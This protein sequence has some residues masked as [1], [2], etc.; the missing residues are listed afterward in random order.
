MIGQMRIKSIT[1]LTLLFCLLLNEFESTYAWSPPNVQKIETEFRWNRMP[2]RHLRRTTTVVNAISNDHDTHNNK[3]YQNGIFLKSISKQIVASGV[4]LIASAF[5]C[6]DNALAASDMPVGKRYW[7]IMESSS[8]EERIHANEALLD[9]AVGTI[10]TQYYDNTGGNNFA[11]S[12]FY[13]QW[14][15][16]RRMAVSG[17]AGA[18]TPSRR[19]ALPVDIPKGVSLDTRDGAVQGLRWLVGSLNDPFSKYLTREELQQE[20][21]LIGQDGFLGTGAIVEAP[22][23]R[24]RPKMSSDKA[25]SP[26]SVQDFHGLKKVLSIARAANLPVVTAVEPDS[27]AERAGF[28]VG[29]RI[30]AVGS[31]SFLGWS[32]QEV[33]KTLATKYNAQSYFGQAELTIAKPVYAF[34]ES[35]TRD[36]VVGYRPSR[37]HLPTK[38]T[39]SVP[40][41]QIH[42]E[43]AASGGDNIVHYQLL[44]S[45]TGSIFDHF[46]SANVIQDDYKVGYIR[47]TRFSK[48]STN[49]YL[50]AVQ[51]LESAGA[52]SYI[53]DLRNNYG[54]KFQD[55]LLLASTLIRDPHAILC[56][57]IYSRAVLS[58]PAL[59]LFCSFYLSSKATP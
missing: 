34:P 3:N 37:V 30:V 23:A 7:C 49:G 45:S 22:Q 40:T 21:S 33:S 42:N 43:L 8:K 5:L 20:L 53:L 52:Q 12:D 51:E 1:A 19:E 48:A 54:G 38:A 10:N 29:D 56:K 36:V 15:S 25:I 41:F 59:N 32:R 46:H 35:S 14:R 47:L 24:A 50:N 2:C 27:P 6:F 58:C 17:E 9:Y 57:R 16:F 44:S 55:A 18:Y 31:N 4:L 39:E 28:V 26:L 13:R 11:P